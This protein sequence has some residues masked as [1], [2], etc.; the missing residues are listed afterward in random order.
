MSSSLRGIVIA[1]SLLGLAGCNQGS[2]YAFALIIPPDIPVG[3]LSGW[4]PFWFWDEKAAFEKWT[5]CERFRE[6]WVWT[7]EAAQSGEWFREKATACLA[8]EVPAPSTSAEPWILY[9]AGEWFPEPRRRRAPW[10]IECVTKPFLPA[11][12]DWPRGFNRSSSPGMPEF[13]FL[14]SVLRKAAGDAARRGRLSR[15]VSETLRRVE[16]ARCVPLR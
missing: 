2:P 7:A 16:R 15:E 3:G 4:A 9:R 10:F 11:A 6:F 1:L 13:E 5:Q 14:D 12:T 8:Q